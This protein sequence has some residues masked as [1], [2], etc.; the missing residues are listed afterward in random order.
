MPERGESNCVENARPLSKP[1]DT[2]Y[3]H[4]R[5]SVAFIDVTRL[6]GWLAV[7]EQESYLASLLRCLRGIK[8]TYKKK[9]QT[10]EIR[11]LKEILFLFIPVT[12]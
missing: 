8:V 3:H 12:S 5:S 11:E 6:S 7:R 1:R 4:R 10:N 2:S 9:R